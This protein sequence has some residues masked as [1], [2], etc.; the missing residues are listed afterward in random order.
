[1]KW[2]SWLQSLW[3]LFYP[4]YCVVCGS[5]LTEMEE[6]VCITCLSK[7]PRVPNAKEAGNE[8]EKRFWGKADLVHA[9]AYFYYERGSDFDAILF[10][11]K[12][13]GQK[14][15][16]AIMGKIVANDLIRSDFFKE[17]DFIIPIPLHPKRYKKRG[18]NQSEW[19][20]KGVSEITDLPVF[21]QL[22]Q[23]VVNT[24]TQ[25]RKNAWQR[26]ENVQHV[27]QL[28]YAKDLEG[29]HVL[30]IDDVLTTGATM[31]ACIDE[32]KQVPEVKISVLTLAAVR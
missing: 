30:L 24:K 5:V 6:G 32:L 22:V 11:M 14:E 8:V 23:R 10:Q 27:F 4:R 2:N 28:V 17:I 29:K 7:L 20:A 25:T 3:E 19:I 21:S 31:L 9:V 12:Y 18:Y 1:M 15:L 13:H 16:A 26:W